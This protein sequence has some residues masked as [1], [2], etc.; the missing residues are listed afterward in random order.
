MNVRRSWA[1]CRHDLRRLASTP[2]AWAVLILTFL[3]A[4]NQFSPVRQMLA[5]EGLTLS[6]PGM[7]LYMLCDTQV[8]LMLGLGL[9][10]LLFDAPFL[11][12]TQRYIITRTGRG[13][14][15]LGQTLYVGAAALAYLLFFLA[16]LLA[17]QAPWTDWSEGWSGGLDELVHYGAYEYY[18]TMLDYDPWL[19][20]TYSPW[21]GLALTG[22]LHLL[23]YTALGLILFAFNCLT[24]SRLGFLPCTGLL[25][26]D[27][28]M[29]EYFMENVYYFSPVTLCRLTALDY[30]DEMGRPPAWYAAVV[31]AVLVGLLGWVCVGAAR[32]K[33]LSL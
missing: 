9:V 1:C 22:G 14:W 26:W 30:G 27:A 29:E 13:S 21:G 18:N 5:E 23:A 19:M 3:F 7:A 15:G 4:E 24:R 25:L 17:L 32:R 16:C 20:E 33:E 31:L 11:D 10:M 8:T 12:E 6:F 28:V 2:R